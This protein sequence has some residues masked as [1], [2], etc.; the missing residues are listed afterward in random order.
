MRWTQAAET[1]ERVG[2]REAGCMR[3]ISSQSH[4]QTRA[5][6]AKGDA[7]SCGL[8]ELPGEKPRQ[9]NPDKEKAQEPAS[10]SGWGSG[11]GA[12]ESEERA[13]WK[14]RE[15]A[16]QAA[17]VPLYGRRARGRAGRSL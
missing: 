3:P 6:E 2:T 14:V 10:G 13:S 15:Q 4:K 11:S 12:G 5:A 8:P 1:E 17:G 16:G 9:K 7:D